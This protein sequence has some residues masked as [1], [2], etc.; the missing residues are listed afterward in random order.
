MDKE[1]YL[2]SYLEILHQVQLW[3]LSNSLIRGYYLCHAVMSRAEYSY[4]K[5][6]GKA[7]HWPCYDAELYQDDICRR[8]RMD[9]EAFMAMKGIKNTFK[10][11]HKGFNCLYWNTGLHPLYAIR[12]ECLN[13]CIAKEE[14]RRALLKTLIPDAEA[15]D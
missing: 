7:P 11:R 3:G 12:M 8:F 2:P 14:E 4:Y 9:L 10:V 13:F 5:V 15:L 6:T 1:Q